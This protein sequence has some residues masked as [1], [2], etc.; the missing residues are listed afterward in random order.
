VEVRPAS[1][2]SATKSN[3]SLNKIQR[4]A[5]N[6]MNY[7]TKQRIGKDSSGN[8]PAAAALRMILVA[9]FDT[10]QQNSRRTR[11]PS[12]KSHKGQCNIPHSKIAAGT[13]GYAATAL[14]EWFGSQAV[15]L[16]SL[17]QGFLCALRRAAARTA[18][19]QKHKGLPK[20]IYQFLIASPGRK[21]AELSRIR[22][23]SAFGRTEAEARAHLAG[24]H[25][26]FL[27]RTPAR[28]GGAA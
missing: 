19:V 11:H 9:G 18:F 2:H 28:K 17:Q 15:R 16:Q 6:V 4:K 23:V 13:G 24:L 7:A 22:I 5:S 26:V 21:L 14:E 27:S 12:A 1:L 10:R 20:M 25:L 3:D 8:L